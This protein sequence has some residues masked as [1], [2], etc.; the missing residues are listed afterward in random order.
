MLAPLA[1]IGRPRVDGERWVII[2][3]GSRQVPDHAAP[4]D[5]E[6]RVSVATMAKVLNLMN[7]MNL[8]NISG[9]RRG[10]I[11]P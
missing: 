2:V 5:R 1:V 3:P 9:I 8:M 7:L 4:E 6:Q 10:I 11:F